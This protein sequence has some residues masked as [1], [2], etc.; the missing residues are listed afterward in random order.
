MKRGFQCSSVVLIR[1]IIDEVQTEPKT[2]LTEITAQQNGS[3]DK[4][5]QVASKRLMYILSINIMKREVDRKRIENGTFAVQ[6]NEWKRSSE[7]ARKRISM[8]ITA[9]RVVRTTVMQLAMRLDWR[10]SIWWGHDTIQR[11]A[12]LRFCTG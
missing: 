4:L 7:K 3:Y 10:Q 9:C 8:Q 1:K 5:D 12:I 2:S 11:R 6:L